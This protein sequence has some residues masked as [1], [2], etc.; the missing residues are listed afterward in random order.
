[1]IE[2]SLFD[3]NVIKQNRKDDQK[4]TMHRFKVLFYNRDND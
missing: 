4:T 2:Y 3:I 1:M